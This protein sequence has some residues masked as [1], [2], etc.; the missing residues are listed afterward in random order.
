[1]QHL[2]LGLP[3]AHLLPPP[4]AGPLVI[5]PT[6]S[7]FPPGFG[8]PPHPPEQAGSMTGDKSEVILPEQVCARAGGQGGRPS[9]G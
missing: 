3:W 9:L 8:G 4:P 6:A 5:F 7:V 2:F 1:M